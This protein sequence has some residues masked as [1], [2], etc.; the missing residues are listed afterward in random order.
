MQERVRKN[1]SSEP[2]LLL[3]SFDKKN[4]SKSFQYSICMLHIENEDKRDCKHYGHNT[5]IRC[6]IDC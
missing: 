6:I 2:C 4:V 3:A 1:E 5:A